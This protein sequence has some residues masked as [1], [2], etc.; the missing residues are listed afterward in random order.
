MTATMTPTTGFGR[1]NCPWCGKSLKG[2]HVCAK[3]PSSAN[4]ADLDDPGTV[5]ARKLSDD[6]QW[7]ADR[8]AEEQAWL[9]DMERDWGVSD[10]HP[11]FTEEGIADSLRD[12]AWNRDETDI[13]EGEVSLLLARQ[14]MAQAHG[15]VIRSGPSDAGVRFVDFDHRLHCLPVNECVCCG[16][17][18]PAGINRDGLCDI[19]SSWDEGG[20]K[21]LPAYLSV[22]DKHGDMFEI[23]PTVPLARDDVWNPVDEDTDDY[24]RTAAQAMTACFTREPDALL[25]I[26]EVA[27]EMRAA[28]RQYKRAAIAKK[29]ARAPLWND[30]RDGPW[31]EADDERFDRYVDDEVAYSLTLSHVACEL[32]VHRMVESTG[33]LYVD[34]NGVIRRLRDAALPYQDM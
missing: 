17:W 24:S 31:T 25:T 18:L 33:S 29:A 1:G 34:D 20:D 30:E 5:L 11:S 32:D 6:P 26:Q 27:D 21:A 10:S 4:P 3:R 2:G 19:C 22:T 23:S 13:P 12:W 8:A 14:V 16:R 28:E 7:V 9:L 15:A